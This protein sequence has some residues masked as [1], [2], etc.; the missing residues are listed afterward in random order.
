MLYTVSQSCKILEQLLCIFFFFSC[1]E[2]CGSE[3]AGSAAGMQ[4]SA[5]LAQSL[6][7]LHTGISIIPWTGTTPHHNSCSFCSFY[8]LTHYK[9]NTRVKLLLQLYLHYLEPISELLDILI[10]VCK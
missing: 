2:D 7:R 8:S 1:P 10:Y 5:Q 4:V 9:T 3:E 6:W